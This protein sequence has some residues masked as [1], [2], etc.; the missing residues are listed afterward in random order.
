[1]EIFTAYT[2]MLKAEIQGGKMTSCRQIIKILIQQLA[3][4]LSS[5]MSLDAKHRQHMSCLTQWLQLGA[6][7]K[8]LKMDCAGLTLSIYCLAQALAREIP[9]LARVAMVVSFTG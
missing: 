2:S 4:S 1:M 5:S 6:K 3:G 9:V 7:K 8:G